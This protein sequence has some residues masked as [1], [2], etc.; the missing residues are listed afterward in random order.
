MSLKLWMTDFTS[1]NVDKRHSSY[2]NFLFLCALVYPIDT[3]TLVDG[4]EKMT[5]QMGLSAHSLPVLV[6]LLL[7]SH[8]FMHGHLCNSFPFPNSVKLCFPFS[9]MY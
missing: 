2:S 7:K 4:E 1:L 5:S 9:D 3:A 6:Q 8:L